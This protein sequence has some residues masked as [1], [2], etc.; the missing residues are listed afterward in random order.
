M[1]EWSVVL[2]LA[3]ISSL[4]H[5]VSMC[6]GFV[7]SYSASI[8]ADASV[9]RKNVIHLLYNVGRLSSYVFLGLVFGALGVVLSVTPLSKG[10]LFIVL[11]VFMII[12][13][14]SLVDNISINRY[15]KIPF[16]DTKIKQLFAKANSQNTLINYYLLGV[17]N[18][19]IPCGLVYF[20]LAMAVQGGSALHGAGVMLVFALATIPIMYTV[21]MLYG[22]L[23]KIPKKW[24]TY[25]SVFLIF[26]Y[27]VFTFAKGVMMLQKAL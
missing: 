8:E 10:V 19:L 25:F 22:F 7:F 17:G 2:P 15:L 13:A 9:L 27:G 16:L 20:F 1:S 23:Q 14:L 26:G 24:M 4:G 12:F 3:F 18:G 6:G 5:C 11:G 21:G